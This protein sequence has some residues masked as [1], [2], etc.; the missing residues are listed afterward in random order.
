MEQSLFLY[1]KTVA[2]PG[3]SCK[4]GD[5][6]KQCEALTNKGQPRA[7]DESY[8]N[9]VHLSAQHQ[10]DKECQRDLIHDPMETVML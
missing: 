2:G 5:I 8:T 9:M 4:Q 1:S 7:R 6:V 3:N 10:Q